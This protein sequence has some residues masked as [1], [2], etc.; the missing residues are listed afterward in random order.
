MMF[1]LVCCSVLMISLV[2]VKFFSWV[3]VSLFLLVVLVRF[4]VL[5]ISGLVVECL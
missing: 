5:C 2:V 1:L 3:G 4:R